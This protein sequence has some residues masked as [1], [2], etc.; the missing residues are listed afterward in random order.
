MDTTESE[1]LAS[2]MDLYAL[3]VLPMSSCLDRCELIPYAASKYSMDRSIL[4]QHEYIITSLYCG[5]VLG[6]KEYVLHTI[7]QR[8][9]MWDL[10]C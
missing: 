2:A 9:S 10:M 8:Q 7:I 1:F 4:C 3:Q 6:L 5:H